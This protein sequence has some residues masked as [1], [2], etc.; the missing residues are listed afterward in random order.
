VS[1][2]QPPPHDG[3]APDYRQTRTGIRCYPG[4]ALPSLCLR[5]LPPPPSIRTEPTLTSRVLACLDSPRRQ[6]DV[7]QLLGLDAERVSGA[8]TALRRQGHIYQ[9]LRGYWGVTP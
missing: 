2:C 1:R 5:H 6:G 3:C 4:R 9:P 7:Q 8:L